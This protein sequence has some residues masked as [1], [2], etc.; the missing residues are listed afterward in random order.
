M[1]GASI[2]LNNDIGYYEIHK[3]KYL[4]VIYLKETEGLVDRNY[5]PVFCAEDGGSLICSGAVTLWDNVTLQ[6][7]FPG[8]Q[9]S[10]F[11]RIH[12]DT[13]KTINF[14]YAKGRN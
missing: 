8:A 1:S 11:A 10:D 12:Q 9:L 13:L 7:N 6:Y 5:P 14:A 3:E 2:K 4:H